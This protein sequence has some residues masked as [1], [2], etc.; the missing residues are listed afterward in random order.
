MRTYLV[1]DSWFNIRFSQLPLWA[2]SKTI[3]EKNVNKRV[4]LGH[5]LSKQRTP[6]S[7]S[8]YFGWVLPTSAGFS[9]ML[10]VQKK[11]IAFGNEQNTFWM[12]EK[13]YSDFINA[14]PILISLQ[15]SN[16]QKS[17]TKKY[18]S[19]LAERNAQFLL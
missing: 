7:V 10:S 11:K 4:F 1:V 19:V 14:R 2:M 13:W 3:K 18:S 9:T 5:S 6:C 12:M 17:K 8:A 15:V 16:D